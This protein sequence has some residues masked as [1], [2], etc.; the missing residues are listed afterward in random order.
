MDM[1]TKELET[2]IQEF[3]I[4]KG[5]QFGIWGTCRHSTGID[6]HCALVRPKYSPITGGSY[7]LAVDPI[8]VKGWV[9]RPPYSYTEWQCIWQE[10][11][12]TPEE[13]VAILEKRIS[14]P[15]GCWG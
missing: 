4:S 15:T 7:T 2:K 5:F 10:L 11:Y 1:D 8:T 12:S 14:P 6:F 3:L 13:L 9:I